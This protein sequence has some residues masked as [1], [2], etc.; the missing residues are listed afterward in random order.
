[1][2]L[3]DTTSTAREDSDIRRSVLPGGLR[4]VTEH[5]SGTHGVHVGWFVGVGSRHETARQHGCSHV[6]EHVLFKGTRRRDAA[7]VSAAVERVGGDLNAWTGR[8]HT[9]FHARVLR[10]DLPLALDV[11]GDMLTDSVLREAD[12]A[13]EKEVIL[14]EIAMHRDDPLELTQ[15]L[16]H[17]SLFG[18]DPLARPVIGTEASI[19]AL[20]RNQVRSFW[21]RHYRTAR[22]VISVVGDVDHDRVV[23]QVAQLRVPEGEPLTR[24]PAVL[25]QQAG[26]VR[27]HWTRL[28]QTSVS[29]GFPGFARDDE[30]RF[31]LSVLTTALGGGMSSR[32]FQRVREQRALAYAIDS[33][34]STWRGAGLASID[35]QALPGRTASIVDEVRGIVTDVVEHGITEDELQAAITLIEGQTRL[36]LDSGST[37]MT[38]LGLTWL[39]DDLRSVDDVLQGYRQVTRDA[40]TDVARQVLGNRP[41]LALAGGRTPLRAVERVL[42]RW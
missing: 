31:A 34:D 12:L 27:H 1:M 35:W 9:A 30:R 38:R 25:V 6:L 4:V 8:D 24:E 7:E 20:S 41:H 23:D 36:A 18:T 29:L 2:S 33:S 15:E 37:S 11:L 5:R 16:V 40:V 22:S 26:E 10:R 19:T 39:S 21:R 28:A 3:I 14:D 17:G 42:D 13:S 32:L